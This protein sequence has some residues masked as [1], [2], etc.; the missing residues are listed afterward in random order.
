MEKEYE[1]EVDELYVE[2]K[3]KDKQFSI[4][5]G[6]CYVFDYEDAPESG[7]LSVSSDIEI[8]VKAIIEE[9]KSPNHYWYGINSWKDGKRVDGDTFRAR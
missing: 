6:D 4:R 1:I 7:V 3:F 5:N 2:I 8:V 9:L